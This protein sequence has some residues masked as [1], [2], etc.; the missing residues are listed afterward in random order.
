MC[1]SF[2]LLTGVQPALCHRLARFARREPK[3]SQDAQK[4]M[5]KRHQNLISFRRPLGTQFFRPKSRQEAPAPQ[6]A[7]ED[8]VGPRLLG[9]DL[10]GGRQE[11]G[12]QNLCVR[13]LV[14]GDGLGRTRRPGDCDPTLRPELGGGLKTPLGGVPPPLVFD[15]GRFVAWT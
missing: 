14:Q 13:N 6:I 2:G 10:G 11:T 9:E 1:V 12:S 15:F 7:A 5:L 4:S 3:R 8:G